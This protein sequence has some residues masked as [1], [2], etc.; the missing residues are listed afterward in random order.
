MPASLVDSLVRRNVVSR[1][2]AISEIFVG[3]ATLIDKMLGAFANGLER[4]KAG[5]EEVREKT[6]RRKRT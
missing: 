5:Q 2:V 4:G 1:S 3:D 6:S